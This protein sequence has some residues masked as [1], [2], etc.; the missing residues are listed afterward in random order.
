MSDIMYIVHCAW[1]RSWRCV[2]VRVCQ[3]QKKLLC[4][5][6]GAS[7]WQGLWSDKLSHW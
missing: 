3:R 7:A 1:K 2:T 4:G 5:N 6:L